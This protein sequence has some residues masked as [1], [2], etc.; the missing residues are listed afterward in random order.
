MYSKQYV[1]NLK[2]MPCRERNTWNTLTDCNSQ[3]TQ[4]G[5]AMEWGGMGWGKRQRQGGRGRRRKI[6]SNSRTGG[7]LLSF[8]FS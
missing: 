8:S 6:I 5:S 1:C 4:V 2:Q 3:P 7:A